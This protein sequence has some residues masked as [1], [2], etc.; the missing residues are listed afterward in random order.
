MIGWPIS[1]SPIVFGNPNCFQTPATIGNIRL[2]ITPR[3]PS[4][5]KTEA[6]DNRAAR[7][8]A[9]VKGIHGALDYI[10]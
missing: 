3:C 5:E 8:S 4:P 10:A 2:D 9:M 1:Q 6:R 7:D